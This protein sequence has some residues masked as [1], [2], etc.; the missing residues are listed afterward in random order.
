MAKCDVCEGRSQ[1]RLCTVH[2]MILRD[3]LRDLPQW[4]E[5]LA[6]AAVGNVRLGDN[7]RRGCRPDVLHPYTGPDDKRNADNLEK[8]IHDGAFRRDRLLAAGRVNA[9]ASRLHDSA[10][11]TLTTWV[12]HMCETHGMQA[13]PPKRTVSLEFI[14]PLLPG[15]RRINQDATPSLAYLA[16]WLERRTHTIAGDEAAKECHDDMVDLTDR[17]KRV[18]NRPNP[19]KFCGPCPTLLT[20]EE[21]AKLVGGGEEDREEC[22]TRLYAKPKADRV[23]C[24][25]CHLEYETKD[26]QA[27]HYE[28][29][30]D[31]LFTIRELVDFVLP[32]LGEPIS[33][34]LLYKWAKIGA[35]PV[36][37]YAA[38]GDIMLKLGDVRRI[39]EDPPRRKPG[40]KPGVNHKRVVSC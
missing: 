31:R 23:T 13:W 33:Q 8:A 20:D 30:G 2:E 9:K 29:S 39:R 12:R 1:L 24:P 35:L 27:W 6:D 4:L 22:H 26:V 15:W 14:G 36:P 25:T 38:N 34:Q 19:P 18:I 5:W 11:N 40:R 17:I 32:R 37:G 10:R 7:G 16:R 28:Q 3:T 21:R